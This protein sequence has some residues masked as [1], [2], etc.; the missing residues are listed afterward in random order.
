MRERTVEE[1]LQDGTN[2]SNTFN[3]TNGDITIMATPED[4]RK[5]VDK[6]TFHHDAYLP[7]QERYH[8]NQLRQDFSD[9]FFRALSMMLSRQ[10]AATDAA[11]DKLVYELYGLTAEEIRVVE[12]SGKA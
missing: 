5:L 4:I 1:K 9:P 6:Y 2:K 3:V 7:G 10:I 12:G 11:I 8:E